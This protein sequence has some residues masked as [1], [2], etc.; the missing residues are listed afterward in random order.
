MKLRKKEDRNDTSNLSL[1]YHFL[2]NFNLNSVY[3]IF[4]LKYRDQ[5]DFPFINIR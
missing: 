2:K 1:W 4:L 3:E 5:H